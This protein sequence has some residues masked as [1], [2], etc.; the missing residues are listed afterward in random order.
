MLKDICWVQAC[1]VSYVS[2]WNKQTCRDPF[3]NLYFRINTTC[4]LLRVNELY[5]HWDIDKLGLIPVLSCT[6]QALVIHSI[7]HKIETKIFLHLLFFHT[8]L[9]WARNNVDIFISRSWVCGT[10]IS[11]WLMSMQTYSSIHPSFG[12]P[13]KCS[14]NVDIFISCS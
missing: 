2:G 12:F 6:I 1:I 14:N 8:S 11:L 10:N 7:N 9:S 5:F 4:R 13:P 3:E